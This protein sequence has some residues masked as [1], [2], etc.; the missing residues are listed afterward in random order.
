MQTRKAKAQP[1]RT[2]MK[3][4]CWK[5]RTQTERE[6]EI[7]KYRPRKSGRQIPKEV[8]IDSLDFSSHPSGRVL[9]DR[10]TYD[11]SL[12]SHLLQDSQT[13]S[14]SFFTFIEHSASES[15]T[16]P[17]LCSTN[18][19]KQAGEEWRLQV[20]YDRIF[21]ITPSTSRASCVAIPV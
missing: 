8:P 21:A 20:S 4:E 16:P 2:R 11:L 7:Q 3:T 12:S 6:S 13:F 14:L 15:F 1:L 9:T 18:Q 10:Q 19:P 5:G 17:T